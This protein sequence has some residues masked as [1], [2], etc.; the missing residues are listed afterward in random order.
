LNDNSKKLMTGDF[1]NH[2][3]A[4]QKTQGMSFASEKNKE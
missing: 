1:E 2:F 4:L 3:S